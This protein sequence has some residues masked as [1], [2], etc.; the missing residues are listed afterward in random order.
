MVF[1]QIIEGLMSYGTVSL[2]GNEEMRNVA[3]GADVV[4]YSSPASF[5]TGRVRVAKQ[6][7]VSTTG[8]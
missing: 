1:L 5:P 4:P 6:M 2:F 7:M 8:D 3:I